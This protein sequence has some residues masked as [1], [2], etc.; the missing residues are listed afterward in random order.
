MYNTMH[1]C[2]SV[3]N[4]KLRMCTKGKEKFFFF[5]YPVHFSIQLQKHMNFDKFKISLNLS[6]LFY[7][8]YLEWAI[9]YKMVLNMFFLYL[10]IMGILKENGIHFRLDGQYLHILFCLGTF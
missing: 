7:Q 10:C 2:T 8:T 3:F 6:T 9:Y 5:S 4:E 1:I